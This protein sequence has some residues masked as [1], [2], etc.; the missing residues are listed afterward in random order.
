LLVPSYAPFILIWFLS[1][2]TTRKKKILTGVTVSA[3]YIS[4]YS[5]LEARIHHF[6]VPSIAADDDAGEADDDAVEAA[7]EEQEAA[8]GVGAQPATSAPHCVNE[9]EE[10]AADG[11][12]STGTQQ[13]EKGKVGE[14][15]DEDEDGD[16]SEW[17]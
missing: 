17:D 11:P 8:T 15:E 10:K 13:A 2:M 6:C 3:R 9:A 16:W 12:A 14:D 5:P 4:L 7:G 1:Q